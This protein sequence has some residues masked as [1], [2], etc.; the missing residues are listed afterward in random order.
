M[1]AQPRK[2]IARGIIRKLNALLFY[3]KVCSLHLPI[4]LQSA[5]KVKTKTAMNGNT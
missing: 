1:L 5:V 3:S 2:A 4:P